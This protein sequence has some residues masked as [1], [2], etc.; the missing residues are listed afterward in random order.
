AELERDGVAG[1]AFGLGRSRSTLIEGE[2]DRSCLELRPL[3]GLFS[4]Q[5]RQ[6]QDVT[7]PVHRSVPVLYPEHDDPE[8][9]LHRPSSSP[10]PVA[11]LLGAMPQPPR[12]CG[13]EVTDFLSCRTA[14]TQPRTRAPD[15]ALDERQS[16]AASRRA[17]SRRRSL[18]S[19]GMSS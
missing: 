7:I 3:R 9:H 15:A 18:N 16:R 6:P 8:L 2:M 13:R 19:E 1:H 12:T 10:I 11:P 14:L 5:L 4:V 17:S